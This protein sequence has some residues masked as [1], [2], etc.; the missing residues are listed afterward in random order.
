MITLILRSEI[1][2]NLTNI[3]KIMIMVVAILSN[4]LAIVM[5]MI[6]DLILLKMIE[7]R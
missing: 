2:M 6:L 7:G 5:I 4:V 1:S 3:K